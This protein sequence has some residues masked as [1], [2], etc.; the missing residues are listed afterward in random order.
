MTG[1]I[2]IVDDEQA[3]CELLETDLRLRDFETEWHTSAADAVQAVNRRD[4]DVVLTD[5]NMPG[6][7]GIQ[8]C[9][10]IASHRLW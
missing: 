4:Y 1:K 10:H 6:T 8:L 5:L 9:E 7:N 2:L 3:M